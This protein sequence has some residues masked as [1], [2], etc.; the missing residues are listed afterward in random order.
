MIE[1]VKELSESTVQ[2]PVEEQPFLADYPEILEPKHIREILQIGEKQTYE[3]L[4]QSPPPFHFVRI[5]RCIKISKPTFI[6]WITGTP[7]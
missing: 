2:A 6:K 3:F 7:N 4:N 5:G 1:K